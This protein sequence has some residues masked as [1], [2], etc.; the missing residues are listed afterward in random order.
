MC[1]G[2]VVGILLASQK[3]E[4]DS[5]N[6]DTQAPFERPGAPINRDKQAQALV[7]NSIVM[8]NRSGGYDS[9]GTP[10]RRTW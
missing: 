5:Q 8:V 9:L 2:V 7:T 1:G 3:A 4:I 10:E 6:G